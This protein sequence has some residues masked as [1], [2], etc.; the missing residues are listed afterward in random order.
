MSDKDRR[1]ILILC[2]AEILGMLGTSSFAALLVR[3]GSIWHLSSTDAGWISGIYYGG[4]T[5]AVPGLVT[6]TDRVDAKIVY[7]FATILGAAAALGFA[8]L[9]TGFWSA[10]LFRGIAGVGLAGTYMPGL[11]ALAD[12]MEGNRQSRA[13]AFYTSCFGIGVSLSFFV[14]GKIADLF[15]WRVG[16]AMAAAGSAAAFLLIAGFVEPRLP[17]AAVARRERL[18]NF[19]VV[20]RNRA[21]LV[22]MVAY[23]A[24]SFE[25][26]AF[27]AWIAAFF[28]FA[29]TLTMAVGTRPDPAT[30][31]AFV[32]L[33]S[34]PAS[35]GGNE[36]ALRFGRRRTL[37]VVMS[38]SAV[39]AFLVGFTAVLPLAAVVLA[40]FCYGAFVSGDS[41]ALTASLVAV[42][43]PDR[44][45]ATMAVYSTLGFAGGFLGPIVFGVVLDV[46]GAHHL[47]GWVA[48]FSCLGLAVGIGPMV[49]GLVPGAEA[50]SRSPVVGESGVQN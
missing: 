43:D 26:F 3:L 48:G 7:L 15:G 37:I 23:A 17:P 21:A 10:L 38:I 41:A 27:R 18:L 40:C 34:L 45:G 47:I 13:V 49:L 2:L 44:R 30:I 28:A 25:L 50:L 32:V 39:I 8:V 22:V 6:L 31:A 9:A 14:T 12:R 1:L 16:F 24:H 33:V 5:L 11:K 20:L 35:I 4:Y 19:G 46:F 36:F 29:E 42:A